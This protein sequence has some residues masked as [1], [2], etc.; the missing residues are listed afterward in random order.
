[1]L[2]RR[3]CEE[4]SD[5]A[6][7]GVCPPSPAPA[8]LDCHAALAMT[9]E[10][11]AMLLSSRATAHHPEAQVVILNSFQAPPQDR[12]PP[13]EILSRRPPQGKQVQDDKC[14]PPPFVLSLS[15]DVERAPT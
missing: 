1:M 4:H 5:A 8:A 9:G 2:R 7:Q 6:I 13:P 15:K 12:A 3:H 14:A 10:A 11:G